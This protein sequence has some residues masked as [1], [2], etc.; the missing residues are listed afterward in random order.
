M[1]VRRNLRAFVDRRSI[2]IGCIVYRVELLS[3]N[4]RKHPARQLIEQQNDLATTLLPPRVENN[5]R[6]H[7]V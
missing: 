7:L 1:C 4:L 5:T 3:G 2:V 6:L